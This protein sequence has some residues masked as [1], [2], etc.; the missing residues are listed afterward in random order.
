MVRVGL[1]GFGMAGQ[2]FHAP[3]IRA[4]P[5]MELACILE[6]S[7]SLARQRYPEVRV[8]RTLEELLADQTIA[9]CVVATP[10]ISHFDLARRCLAGRHV[11]VDKPFTTRSQEA[12]ALIELANQQHR[13]L[14]VFQSRRWDGDFKTVR[15]IVDS[16]A[17]GKIVEFEVRYDRF[18]PDPK[19]GWRERPE[20]G[21]GVL[22][23]LG[24][25]L[26]DQ[27]LVLFGAPQAIMAKIF[28]QRECSQVDDAFDVCL[29]YPDLRVMLRARIL[30][31]APGPHFLMHGSRGSFIKYGMDP[32]EE[33]LKK[34]EPVGW[35]PHWGEEAEEHWG[36]LSVV[37]E[38]PRRVRTEPGD[39]R[40]F[41]ENVREA[42][43]HGAALAVKPEEA[44]RSIRVIEL[45][46]Q[47]SESN[48]RVVLQ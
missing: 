10:N 2:V 25:H 44:L 28:C 15:K 39:Y 9:V 23:D 20:P 14:T 19:P 18:R 17:L 7:G 24:A 22:F 43:V 16:G 38:S 3:T 13:L 6:R 11:V 42:I 5:G 47:S 30:A 35:G 27:A 33:V 41:Y 40:G 4:V 32:Q 36:T 31:Y 29:E 26:I 48:C 45:A 21:S 46:R 8:A 37:G 1:I 34:G 12:Q